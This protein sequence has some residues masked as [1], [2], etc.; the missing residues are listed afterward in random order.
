MTKMQH[1]AKLG[2]LRHAMKGGRWVAALLVLASPF[3]ASAQT[4][5]GNRERPS[6]R[7]IAAIDR[8][9]ET[10]WLWG[11]EDVA[12]DGLNQFSDA[13]LAIDART[14]YLRVEGNRLWWRTY[15]SATEAPENN[16]MAYLFVDSDLD[17]NTGLS[18]AAPEVDPAFTEDKSLGGYEYVVAVRGDG[19]QA[20][21]WSLNPEE[22]AFVA[23]TVTASQLIGESDV[24]LDPLRVGDDDHGY[25]QAS[26]ANDLVEV[27]AQCQARFYVRTTNQTKS[28]GAG[29]LEVGEAI[30]CTPADVN[31]NAVPDVL[32]P[33]AACHSD[34][35]CPSGG[36]CWD[37][38]CW[39]APVCFDD[40]DCPKNA[41][42][43]SGS[44]IAISGT[45]CRVPSDCITGL[46]VGEQCVV[47]TS[48]AACGAERVCAPDGRCVDEDVAG[49]AAG[50]TGNADANDAGM[51]G[52]DLLE[53]E[54]IQGGPCACRY[55]SDAKQG[56]SSGWLAVA[57]GLIVRHIRRRRERGGSR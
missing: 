52:V 45:D 18:A 14:V 50:G 32:E 40:T 19:A 17:E 48:D 28:L 37:E 57:A 47:C 9:G 43:V 20:T 36:I 56:Q 33:V 41:T 35:Q 8:T 23:A 2:V 29:D 24:I 15:L 3:G 13:E 12:G 39:L 49:P 21:L 6:L 31:T 26:I 51:S 27:A 30:T 11:E 46:C 53:G 44:C 34:A 5:A 38:R 42:C 16:L 7:E 10:N 25:V 54:R 4:W 22:T 55:V 1:L